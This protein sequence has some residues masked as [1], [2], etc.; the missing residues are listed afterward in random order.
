MTV[1]W[2]WSVI[3]AAEYVQNR[4]GRVFCYWSRLLVAFSSGG[5]TSRTN[6]LSGLIIATNA[7]DRTDAMG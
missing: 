5:V 2:R 7:T 4:N 3:A 6:S 1:L